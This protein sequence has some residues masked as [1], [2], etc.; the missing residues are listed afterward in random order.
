MT[1]KYPFR[2]IEKKWQDYWEANRIFEVDLKNSKKPFYN[3]MMFPYPSAE[4]LHVGNVFAFVRDSETRDLE[5]YLVDPFRKKVLSN[6]KCPFAA[7]TAYEVSPDGSRAVAFSRLPTA[8]WV[9]DVKAK[10]W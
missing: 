6:G 5:W 1:E 10:K 3:L 2:D 4:G 8:L 7:F 9:L